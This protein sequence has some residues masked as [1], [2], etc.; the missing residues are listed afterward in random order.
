MVVSAVGI[1]LYY[2]M[3]DEMMHRGEAQLSGR[4]EYFRRLLAKDFP[5]SELSHNPSLLENML[6]HEQDVLRFNVQ[7]QPALIN[8]NPSGL[9]LPDIVPVADSQQISAKSIHYLNTPD[10][11]PVMFAAAQ[12]KMRDS[13]IVNVFAAHYMNGEAR[14]LARFR[15]EILSSVVIAY[16]L[17]AG[18]GFVVIRRG[19]HPLRKMAEE[20]AGIDPTS[21]STRLSIN[22]AP[23]ELQQLILSFNAMLDRL[24]DG[25][26]RLTQFSADLAHEIRTPVGALMGHCQVALYQVRTVNEYETL[27]AN[28]MQELERI[29]RMVENILF[30]ARA[31][32][33]HS[34]L[35][36][37]PLALAS[38]TQRVSDY[39]EGLAE[40]RG[41]MLR[42]QGQGTL[43]ADALLF[44]RAL[45]NLVANAI[46]YGDAQSPVD[47][48]VEHRNDNVL[49][50]VD[51]QG[52]AIPLVKLDKLFDRFYRADASRSEG[53]HS[54]G[55]GLSIVR[56][57]MALHQGQVTVQN[58]AIGKIR[59]TLHFPNVAIE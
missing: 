49:I 7:G 24:A 57:I 40:E 14:M 58:M 22:N 44:Q 56:A 31:S 41:I 2:A 54:N 21:L 32:H 46:H 35:T 27:L 30:L 13:R 25:Y 34:V 6:G 50:H 55:L 19:L 3:K 28:N 10:G 33:A 11:T 9:I 15:L 39:F 17:I 8:V 47:V 53:G 45:S 16:L 42:C 48:W 59:F 20:A 36:I 4:V 26:Q 43:Y 12:V 51:N 52:A 1:Y 38:E 37:V 29:S 23:L 5:L 18:L